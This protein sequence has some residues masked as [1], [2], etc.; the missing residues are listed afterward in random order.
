MEM[1]FEQAEEMLTAAQKERLARLMWD[2][3]DLPQD[4]SDAEKVFCFGLYVF[5]E[6]EDRDQLKKYF[7]P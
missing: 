2:G 4:L 1:S 6:Y 7:T 3:D 5:C